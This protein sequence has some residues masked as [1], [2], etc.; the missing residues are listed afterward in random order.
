M[1]R[2][3]VKTDKI[4]LTAVNETD[5]ATSPP[6]RREK[7]FDELQPGEQ[8]ISITPRNITGFG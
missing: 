6:A 7:T 5:S 4:L 2:G 1:T 8:A 3:M